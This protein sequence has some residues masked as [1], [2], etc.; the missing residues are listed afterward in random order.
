MKDQVKFINLN[1]CADEIF[2]NLAGDAAEDVVGTI[3]FTPPSSPVQGHE[4][5][6]KW[7]KENGSS[8]AEKGLH[9]SQGWWTMAVMSEGIKRVL[10]EG[11]EVNGEN[12]KAALES[13]KDFE[14]GGVT[15]PISFS[16]DSHRGNNSL[17]IYVVENG[18]W[19]QVSDFISANP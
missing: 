1:W 19:T 18:N 17:R 16:A 3:P 12:I 5:P 9:F 7:L 2:I 8:L 13:I 11:K 4:E 10:D 15:S 6:D 14:T